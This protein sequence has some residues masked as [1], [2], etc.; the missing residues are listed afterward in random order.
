MLQPVNRP[1]FLPL[2][3]MAGET[4]LQAVEKFCYLG[5]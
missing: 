4:A 1:T 5:T 2:V 3:I